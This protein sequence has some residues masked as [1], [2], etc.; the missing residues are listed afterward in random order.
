MNKQKLEQNMEGQCSMAIAILLMDPTDKSLNCF[1]VMEN[2]W[3][4]SVF[5]IALSAQS[6]TWP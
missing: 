2:M 4:V 6:R 1:K 3:F 5:V